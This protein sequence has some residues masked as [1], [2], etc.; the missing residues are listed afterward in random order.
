MSLTGQLPWS[1]TAT[2][3]PR[4]ST[5]AVEEKTVGQPESP[6]SPQSIVRSE[7]ADTGSA[8]VVPLARLVS[9]V[10]IIAWAPTVWP[11]VVTDGPLAPYTFHA[12]ADSV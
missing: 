2:G 8:T 9:T 6:A 5:G 3:L 1:S 12:T 10:R 7:P 11:C 4:A